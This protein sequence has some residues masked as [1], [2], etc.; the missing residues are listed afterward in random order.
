PATGLD[1]G[2]TDVGIAFETGEWD[3]HIHHETTDT[4]YAPNEAVLQFGAAS[5]Q[6]ISDLPDFQFLGDAGRST[7]IL[8]QV[9]N[10]NLLFLG[11]AAEEIEDGVFVNNTLRV[12]LVSV[13]GPGNFFVWTLDPLGKPQL[14]FNSADGILSSQ[15]FYLLRTGGHQDMNWAVSAPGTYRVGYRV[16]G[17]LVAGNQ[18]TQSDAAYYTFEV[19]EAKLPQPPQPV[20]TIYLVTDLGTLG[21]TGNHFALDI[22]N[23]GVTTGFSSV[24][25][26]PAS[27]HAFRYAGDGPMEDL[28]TLGGAFSTGRAIN[29][30]D[31]IVGDADTATTSQIFRLK[32]GGAMEAFGDK[33]FTDG[34]NDINDDGIIVGA[35]IVGD[36]A[37][38]FIIATNGNLV[39]LATF[40]GFVSNI[41]AINNEGVMAGWSYNADGRQ[42][43]FRHAGSGPLV[44][45]PYPQ[46]DDIGTL[47]GLTAE[48]HGI[49]QAGK[50]VGK[51]S[52]TNGVPNAFLWTATDGMKDLGSLGGNDAVAWDINNHE[53]VVGRSRF[54]G[55]GSFTHGWVWTADHG[56]RDLNE[57]VPFGTDHEI[58]SIYALNDDNWLVGEALR[59]SD[60]RRRPVLLKPAKLLTRGHTDV[61]AVYENGEWELEVHAESLDEE[62]EPGAALLRLPAL[63]QTTV[64]TNSTFA[65]LGSAGS[66]V[67]VLS[68][69]EN[70]KLLFLGLATE[71]IERGLFVND[72][73]KFTLKNVEGPGHFFLYSVD[74]F[75]NASVHWNSRDGFAAADAKTIVAGGH[76]DFNWAFTAPGYYQITIEASGTLANGNQ[77]TASGDATYH[78]DVISLETALAA[79]RDNSGNL[80]LTLN[81]EDGIVYQLQST[82][83]LPNTQWTDMGAAFVGT[84]RD[85]Q[86]SVPLSGNAAFFRVVH[87]R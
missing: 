78:F 49:N 21:G 77:F 82:P 25:Q 57:L 44:N 64:P 16:S 55:S 36:G 80:V 68:Q 24:S 46:G 45:A 75:G 53:V 13:E 29:S 8:P 54:P 51:S 35:M 87:D 14:H 81:T 10:E 28:G 79:T 30:Q 67:W 71:E 56:L 23:D 65:F 84:G 34:A 43:A 50:I 4:E 62:F 52:R 61:G 37:R 1:K 2:H 48:A 41:K 7:W 42:R 17:T 58:V 47:G 70:P 38:G 85:K 66:P 60:A 11:L 83:T 74:G 15:D 31:V 86:I 22:N 12:E 18:F 40:G 6:P 76:Q 19:S 72:E 39:Q 32:P 33:G 5:E 3:L 27:G 59:R 20:D 9:E 73:I 63:A 26:T 69:V